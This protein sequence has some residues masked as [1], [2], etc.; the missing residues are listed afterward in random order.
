MVTAILDKE[1]LKQAVREVL[2]EMLAEDRT[3]LRDII[4]E[5]HEDFML[6]QLLEKERSTKR[7]S[8]KKIF[9]I[10]EGRE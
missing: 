7:V 5:A 6:G 9:D 2:R 3:A 1:Q 4:E 10:L 8:R